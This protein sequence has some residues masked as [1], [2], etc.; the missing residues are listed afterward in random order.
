MRMNSR[1][2]L[3]NTQCYSPE[4]LTQCR[5]APAQYVISATGFF[6][7]TLVNVSILFALCSYC[8][9]VSGSSTRA[10]YEWSLVHVVEIGSSKDRSL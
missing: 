7:V 2:P 6:R 3:S 8:E 9:K 5:R 10:D 1:M 4:L